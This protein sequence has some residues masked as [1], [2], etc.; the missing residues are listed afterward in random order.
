M[1]NITYG[2][3]GATGSVGKALAAKLAERGES[4]RVVGRSEERL[5][6]ELGAMGLLSNTV[7][8]T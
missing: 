3:F 4:L 7:Q 1:R 2:L 6:R 8:R 5:R